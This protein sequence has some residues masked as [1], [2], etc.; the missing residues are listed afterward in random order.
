MNIPISQNAAILLNDERPVHWEDLEKYVHPEPTLVVLEV[1]MTSVGSYQITHTQYDIPWNQPTTQEAVP[2][3]EI[4]SVLVEIYYNHVWFHGPIFAKTL[5]NIGPRDAESVFIGTRTPA[6]HFT[7]ELTYEYSTYKVTYRILPYIDTDSTHLAYLGDNIY[8]GQSNALVPRF[9]RSDEDN[10]EGNL[11]VL[12][13][14]SSFGGPPTETRKSEIL[15][16]LRSQYRGRKMTENKRRE[17]LSR[18]AGPGVLLGD[19]TTGLLLKMDE[20]SRFW[21]CSFWSLPFDQDRADNTTSYSWHAWKACRQRAVRRR[22]DA[23]WDLADARKGVTGDGLK[24]QVDRRGDSPGGLQ[25]GGF[26]AGFQPRTARLR[27][28]L[29]ALRSMLLPKGFLGYEYDSGNDLPKGL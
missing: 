22:E 19:P 1:E 6:L 7:L 26:P 24:P 23:D 28:E 10:A 4:P 8:Y 15:P 16:Q 2:I 9:T 17:L 13:P 14:F 29:N 27:R 12:E 3:P 5:L 25:P 21:V 20:D 18:F 11:W